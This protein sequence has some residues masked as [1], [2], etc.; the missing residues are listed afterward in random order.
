[1][2]RAY[3]FLFFSLAFG[4]SF[5]LKMTLI[6]KP[7]AG[8]AAAS[9]FAAAVL[10]NLMFIRTSGA[11]VGLAGLLLAYNAAPV[12]SPALISLFV[13]QGILLLMAIALL[14]AADVSTSK[15]KALNEA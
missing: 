8:F 1:M 4:S 11:G 7:L 13:I 6:P 5:L 12:H 15:E 14:I 10:S 9:I 3:S 2:L